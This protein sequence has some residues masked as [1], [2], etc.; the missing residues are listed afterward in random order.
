MKSPRFLH[1][2]SL[3]KCCKAKTLL[4]RSRPGGLVTQNCA[5]CGKPEYIKLNELPDIDCDFCGSKLEKAQDRLSNYIYKCLKCDRT[6]LLADQLPNWSDL[7]E[8]HR[9]AA[10]G[11]AALT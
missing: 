6:W 4:V 2:D 8:F 3:S 10:H 11:D 5:K 9:I 1:G 7:F